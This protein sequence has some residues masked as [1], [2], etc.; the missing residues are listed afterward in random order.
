VELLLV[1]FD[2]ELKVFDTPLDYDASCKHSKRD[3]ESKAFFD[4]LLVAFSFGALADSGSFSSLH[5]LDPSLIL[6]RVLR[7]LLHHDH[8]KNK[9]YECGMKQEEAFQTL[10]DNL[11]N[12]SILLLPDG[13]EDFVVYYD[14][15]NQAQ[16]EAFKEENSTAEMLRSLDQLMERK[17][18]EGMYFIWVS[19]IGDVR[20]LIMDKAHASRYLV[21]PGADK[22]YYDLRDMYG[23]HVMVDRL[24]KSA[25]FL[26]IREDY[27]IEK[28]ARL[29]IDEIVPGYGVPML[30]ISDRDGRFTSRFW[31]TLQKALRMRF[32]M[33]TAYHPQTDRQSERTI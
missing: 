8:D 31:K 17:E 24:T 7:L 28:L 22:T 11:C 19:L 14:A 21:H 29:Y 16:S 32:D 1:A 27:K 3:V 20:T 15:S 13:A 33:S 5:L 23:G 18:D 6:R 9:K 4:S 2:T 10:K 26:A 25:H 12:T 30:I